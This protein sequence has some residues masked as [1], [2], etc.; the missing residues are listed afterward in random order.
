MAKYCAICMGVGAKPSRRVCFA[1][2]QLILGNNRECSIRMLRPDFELGSGW[3]GG[4]VNKIRAKH[5]GIKLSGENRE[6]TA[7]ML[8]PYS[9][10]E[11]KAGFWVFRTTNFPG[12]CTS[13]DPF[14][15]KF[16]L[17]DDNS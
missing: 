7:R 6:L 10:E 3:G 13:V 9:P 15:W 2:G 1:Y 16:C 5:S 11:K 14:V 4:F 8:R 12:K 17:L